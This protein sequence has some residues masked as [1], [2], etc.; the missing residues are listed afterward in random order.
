VISKN[1][2]KQKF[3]KKRHKNGG[4]HAPAGA[5]G[6]TRTRGR[7]L[8]DEGGGMGG[9]GGWGGDNVIKKKKKTRRFNN[10]REQERATRKGAVMGEG[11][12]VS[13]SA[14]A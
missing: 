6:K 2:V 4:P 7:G 12:A 11:G 13:P 3:R 8:S 5:P 10:R 1:D 9:G 14:N